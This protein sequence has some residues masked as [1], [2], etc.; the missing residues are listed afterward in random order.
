M[1]SS[2]QVVEIRKAIETTYTDRCTIQE[3]KNAIMDNVSTTTKEIILDEEPCRLSF[4]Q[5]SSAINSNGA[6]SITQEI[7]LFISPDVVIEPG[8]VM[9]ITREGKKER[10][11]ASGKPAVY[12][13]HQEIILELEKR[14]A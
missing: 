10:Y 12:P 6:S 9:E 13:T 7:K 4:K 5:I 8:C 11:K 2:N 3:F 1:L 14:W